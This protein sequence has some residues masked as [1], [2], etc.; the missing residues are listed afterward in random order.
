MI[1][2]Q[3]RVSCGG[4]WEGVGKIGMLLCA[5]CEMGGGTWVDMGLGCRC[6]VRLSGSYVGL[7]RVWAV[8]VDSVVEGRG[9]CVWVV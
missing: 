8:N 1:Y 9:Q 6:V 4:T 2:G 3:P 7:R 5:R